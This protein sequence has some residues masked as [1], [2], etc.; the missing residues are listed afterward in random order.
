MS[1]KLPRRSFVTRVVALPIMAVPAVAVAAS[2]GPVDPAYAAIKDY[3]SALQAHDVAF[4]TDDN[5]TGS[6]CAAASR[7][8]ETAYDALFRARDRLLSTTPTTAA[9]LSALLAFVRDSSHLNDL[10]SAGDERPLRS[11]LKAIAEAAA[12]L[13]GRL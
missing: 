10:M 11:F 13:Q 3:Q 8:Y 5:A 12:G 2:A 1:A 7:A 9:G 4:E 6:D